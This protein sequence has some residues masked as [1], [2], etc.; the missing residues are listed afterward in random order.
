M[1]YST[2]ISTIYSLNTL[3]VVKSRPW[4]F[5]VGYMHTAHATSI[6]HLIRKS[7]YPIRFSKSLILNCCSQTYCMP[8]CCLTCSNWKKVAF[9]RSYMY[10]YLYHDFWKEGHFVSEQQHLRIS[11]VLATLSRDI[12]SNRNLLTKVAV[13]RQ[14]LKIV[15]YCGVCQFSCCTEGVIIALVERNV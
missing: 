4:R 2:M 14:G 6:F 10:I 13:L 12:G 9:C 5:K 7:R 8:T 1:E 11:S 3:W 15:L